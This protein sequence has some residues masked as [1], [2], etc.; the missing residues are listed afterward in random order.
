MILAALSFRAAELWLVSILSLAAVGLGVAW[1]YP[2]QVRPLRW[3]WNWMLPTLRVS[4]LAALGVS[5]LKPV[6][7]RTRTI[8][9]QGAVVIA[10]DRS[11][12]MGVGD[13]RLGSEPDRTQ[14][15]GQ[16]VAMA[17]GLGKLP[18]DVRAGAAGI[19]GQ[20]T[21]LQGLASEVVRAWNEVDFAR[22]SGREPQDAQLRLEQSIGEFLN[23]AKAA[24]DAA[25]AAGARPQVVQQLR[26]LR[27][28]ADDRARWLPSLRES[29]GRAAALI[30]ESQAAADEQLY[31]ANEQVKWVCDSLSLMSRL[32]LAWESLTG[33]RGALLNRL[34]EKVPL[35]GFSIG[36][37]V[38][39]VPLR[40]GGRIP[41]DVP[42]EA[43][44]AVSDLV[45]G[46]RRGIQGLG[47]QPIQAVVLFSDGRIVGAEGGSLPAGLLPAG[48]PVFAVYTASP[49][50]RD[51]AI[52]RVE[53]PRSAFVGQT[54]GVRVN[55]AAVGLDANALAGEA[56]LSAAGAAP[57]EQRAR[58][59]MEFRVTLNRPGLQRIVI[60]APAQRDEASL[61]NN[62]VERWVKVLSQRHKVL[63]V[64]GS[65]GWDFRYA[66][67][68][69]SRTSFVELRSV[70][71]RRG[72][73]GL[74]LRPEQILDQDLVLLYDVPEDALGS[75]Q[76]SAVR[77]L[78]ERRGGSLIWV[79]GV[80]HLVQ[81]YEKAGVADL[82]PYRNPTRPVWRVWP[83][84]SPYYHAVPAPGVADAVALRLDDDPAVSRRRWDELPGFYR[85]LFMPPAELRAGAGVL[86]VERDSPAPQAPLLIERQVGR[87][88]VLFLAIAET[89]RWREKVGD[90]DQARFWGQLLRHAVG[91]PF[92]ASN[93]TLSLD[94]DEVVVNPG[95]KVRLRARVVS[96][97]GE[98][99]PPQLALS[100]L[101]RGRTVRS[102]TLEP[103]ESE[104]AG[105]YAA[106][107]DPLPVGEYELHVTGTDEDAWTGEQS[108]PL[109]VERSYEAEMANLS[110]DPD[111]LNRLVEGTGGKVIPLEQVGLLPD[112][113]AGARL[114][115]PQISE[116]HLWSSWHLFVFVVGCLS[117]EWALRKRFGMA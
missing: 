75:E 36:E 107:I 50:V 103:V 99:T 76:W 62:R 27:Q 91:E 81:N 112:L 101:S 73:V 46:L 10:L 33:G 79:P 94:V 74:G 2:S 116:V 111:T 34:D 56:V 80:T 25:Q 100:V 70:D 58:P 90:R 47:R 66:C 57:L 77:D 97:L 87:G 21:R 16:L 117:A 41:R 84:E 64:A 114:R 4:G 1:L 115:Q 72:Q 53:M 71:V 78:V 109:R 37:T 67:A 85:Y 28:R 89:W 88:K 7:T 108:V 55:L 48:V 24:E 54:I 14:I 102:G 98:A 26:Q 12:S 106:V 35:V 93:G 113:L 11:M 68:A 69:L 92:A 52:T 49:R 29:V 20:I 6:L 32:G 44:A 39:P 65:P 59:V 45:G 82:L 61:A 30:V 63:A 83:G 23:A 43:D 96:A 110:G 3:P 22:L 60:D 86:L 15:I 38:N 95:Q 51:L 13:R 19:A 42:V 105:R 9:E 40:V 8:E 5:L 18:S 104:G 31:R 17:D